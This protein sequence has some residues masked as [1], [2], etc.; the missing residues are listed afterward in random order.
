MAGS[1]ADHEDSGENQA[2]SIVLR[3]LYYLTPHGFG[4]ACRAWAIANEFSTDVDLIFRTTLPEP[5]FR[6]ELKRPFSIFP[7]DF[8]CGCVQSDGVTLDKM[9][10]LKKYKGLAD[11]NARQIGKEVDWVRKER[12]DGIVAD[13]PPF[14]LEVA[15]HAAVPSIAVTNFT[16][17]DIYAPYVNDHPFFQPYLEKMERQYAMA[18]LLLSLHPAMDMPYFPKRVRM[19]IVGRRGKDVRSRV[20]QEYGLDPEKHLGL[21]Y[22]GNFGMDCVPWK[23]LE[24]FFDWEFIGLYPLPGSPGNYHPFKRGI[25]SYPDL[26]ASAEVMVSKIGYGTMAECLLNGTPLIFLP[27]EDFTEYPVLEREILT[28]RYGTKLAPD[29]YYGLNWDLALKALAGRKRPEPLASNGA[30]R[31][32]QIIEEFIA[33][34]GKTE[35]RWPRR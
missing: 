6:E 31:C 34:P 9:E 8:D 24:K 4:H 11:R 26:I 20:I 25:I 27:R 29:E 13:I 19:P 18:D 2:R 28:L 23:K 22:T 14:A 7:A 33:S 35:N 17:H 1:P 16:W 5:V 3:I 10:T 32:A 30:K 12:M 21:I 15:K